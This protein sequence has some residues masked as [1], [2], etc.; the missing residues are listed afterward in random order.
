MVA[1]GRFQ[2]ALSY[3]VIG[4]L[5]LVAVVLVGD[6]IVRHI[7]A[8]ERW[9]DSLGPLGVLAFIVLYVLATSLMLPESVLS[10]AAGALFGLAWGLGAV[11]VGCVT[12]AALQY[13]LSQH[14]L[15]HRIDRVVA[16]RPSFAAIAQ[17]VKQNELQLQ[18][19]LRLT[20]L[21]PASVSYV[22]GASG[23]RFFGFLL[24]SLATFPHLL[25]EVYFGFASKHVA[26]MSSESAEAAHLHDAVVI[27]GLAVTVVVIVFVSRF[28]RK[29]LLAA[30]P[31]QASAGAGASP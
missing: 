8:L 18:L 19:L 17:A 31:G 29:A 27:G 30:V 12:A 25:L 20:P 24:A 1:R 15:R 23:V 28:A 14:V 2:K 5:L 7:G 6:D 16:T 22:L 9:I 4:G 21:N 26:R 13:A 11:L 10:I 3:A